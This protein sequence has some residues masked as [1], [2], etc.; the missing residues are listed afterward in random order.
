VSELAHRVLSVWFELDQDPGLWRLFPGPVVAEIRRLH[1]HRAAHKNLKGML[2]NLCQGWARFLIRNGKDHP[3]SLQRL[4]TGKD[5]DDE[6][7]GMTWIFPWARSIIKPRPNCIQLDGTFE[8]MHPYTLEVLEAIFANESIPIGI[9]L[10][11]SETEV[12]YTRLYDHLTDVLEGED[13]ERLKRIPFMSDQGQALKAFMTKKSLQWL[14]CRRHLIEG[15]GARSLGGDWI[16]RLL[17]CADLVEARICADAIKDEMK[18]LEAQA[19]PLKTIWAQT[20]YAVVV[21]G[22][23]NAVEENKTDMFSL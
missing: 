23:L 14:L 5:K 22:M 20:S 12:S 21:R 4:G 9:G 10:S 3:S 15:A 19:R 8:S 2:E 17:K 13:K 11:P 16:R 7:F 1:A 6:L 18:G